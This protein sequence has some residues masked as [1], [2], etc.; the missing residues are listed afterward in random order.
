MLL[1]QIFPQVPG[2]VAE[3][4]LQQKSHN[5]P[6]HQVCSV[7]A[8][9]CSGDRE[10][11]YGWTNVQEKF[12]E[13]MKGLNSRLELLEGEKVKEEEEALDIARRRLQV[14]LPTPRSPDSRSPITGQPQAEE[15]I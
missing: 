12:D 15:S 10:T 7:H 2:S 14:L 3:A 13:R 1:R 5:C 6:P 8:K 9:F 4:A 11:V